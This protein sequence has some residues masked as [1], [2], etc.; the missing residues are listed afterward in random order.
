MLQLVEPFMVEKREQAAM[1]AL[2]PGN[3]DVELSAKIDAWLRE[4]KTRGYD[5]DSARTAISERWSL[6]DKTKTGP[7]VGSK[8][9]KLGG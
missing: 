5:H 8:K 6:R 7:K 4:T 2:F 3:R 9:R 1:L